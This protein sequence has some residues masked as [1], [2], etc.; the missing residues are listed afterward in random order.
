MAIFSL[1]APEQNLS[2]W[3]EMK[4]GSQRGM[5]CCVRIKIDMS[6]NNGALR[7]PTI[8]RC[9]PEEHVRT[10]TKY[11]YVV[12]WLHND[13]FIEYILHMILLVLLWILSKE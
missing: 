6:S 12:L 1:I 7:D 10:G 13:I 9:K 3:E 8:Y 5:Q 11:K 2:L 4:N